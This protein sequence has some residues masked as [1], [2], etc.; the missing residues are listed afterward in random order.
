MCLSM[1]LSSDRP[2][3][4]VHTSVDLRTSSWAVLRFGRLASKLR[5]TELPIHFCGTGDR[6]HATA[7]PQSCRTASW[8]A[9]SASSA[10]QILEVSCP[11]SMSA[12]SWCTSSQWSSISAAVI[13][14]S[15]TRSAFLAILALPVMPR[16]SRGSM[17][18]SAGGR[19]SK[20][21]KRNPSQEEL[22]TPST[23]LCRSAA[24]RLLPCHPACAVFWPILMSSNLSLAQPDRR[25]R[26]TSNSVFFSPDGV[27]SVELSTPAYSRV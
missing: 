6:R 11:S 23:T 12:G 8:Q 5:P 25:F 24:A 21:S 1:V 15:M 16:S 3:S 18:S 14:W 9:S 7:R 2:Q 27:S 26:M 4:K 10:V 13:R 19:P 17:D 20:P 22:V